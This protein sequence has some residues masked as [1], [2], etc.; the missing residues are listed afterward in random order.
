MTFVNLYLPEPSVQDSPIWVSSGFCP[1][2]GIARA[3]SAVE[4]SKLI[5]CPD[6]L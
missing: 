5:A 4:A 6:R 3:I 2:E 1:F